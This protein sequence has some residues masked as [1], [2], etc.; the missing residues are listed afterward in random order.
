M[1]PGS[2]RQAHASLSVLG[3]TNTTPMPEQPFRSG[4]IALDCKNCKTIDDAKYR[5]EHLGIV[6]NS[7]TDLFLARPVLSQGTC[8]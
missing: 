3:A 5:M 1:C 6:N 7:G 4:L 2:E 8:P